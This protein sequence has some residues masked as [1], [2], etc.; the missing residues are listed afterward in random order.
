MLPSTSAINQSF[1][2]EDAF[3]TGGPAFRVNEIFISINGEGPLTGEAAIFLRLSGCNLRCAY[4]DTQYARSMEQGMFLQIRD[5][6]AELRRFPGIRN[7]TLTGGEPLFAK[8]VGLLITEILRAGYNLNIET[9]GSIDLSPFMELDP[10]RKIIFCCD[11]KLPCSGEESRMYLPNISMLRPGDALKFVIGESSD[12][13]KISSILQGYRPRCLVYL[14]PVFGKTD[15]REI[16][17]KMLSWS[18]T[19][20]V[21]RIRVQLQLHKYIWE[22]CARGV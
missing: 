11:Y 2:K 3:T 9:N 8:D 21:S 19:T 7:V 18:R 4:C 17:E 15:P 16:V 5:I 22:P 13:E 14:S 20:D 6:L 10:D 12:F 1:R